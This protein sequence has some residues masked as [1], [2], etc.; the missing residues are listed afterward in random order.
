MN[1]SPHPTDHPV[2]SLV[3]QHLAAQAATVDAADMLARVRAARHNRNAS[4]GT[5]YTRRLLIRGLWGFGTAAAV[6]LAFIVG[7][8]IGESPVQASAE[9][10]LREARQVHALPLDRC[11]LVQAVPEPDGVLSR[12][13]QFAQP[14]ET[15]LWTRG[16]RF[17]IEST[18]PEKRWAWGREDQGRLWLSLD[19]KRGVSFDKAELMEHDEMFQAVN[20]TCEMFSMR[21]ETL[22]DEVLAGFNLQRDKTETIG[23]VATHRIHAELKPGASSPR[24]RSALLEIDAETRVLRRL[25]LQRTRKGQPLATVT[26]TLVETLAQNDDTYTLEGHLNPDA[27]L[28]GR[29]DNF[30]KRASVVRKFFNLP[31][32][33]GE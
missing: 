3:R 14:R 4:P 25:V 20:I 11:Y 6:L 15:R 33:P 18:N 7:W 12:Y 16:D 30:H 21:V 9:T 17:W 19:G 5:R 28:L 27:E 2:D 1:S 24:L 29:N 22:L 13:P 8:H 31:L 23:S 26:F 10:L 32:I